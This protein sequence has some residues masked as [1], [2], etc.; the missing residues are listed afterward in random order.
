MNKYIVALV[1]LIAASNMNAN[2]QLVLGDTYNTGFN[3]AVALA[4][5]ATDPNFTI[6]SAPVGQSTGINPV[7]PTST[8][9]AWFTSATAQYISPSVD[10]HYPPNQTNGGDLPGDYDYQAILNTSFL[11]PT[12]VDFTGSYAADNTASVTIGGINVTT[13]LAPPNS[14]FGGPLV[15]FTFSLLVGAGSQ[16]THI[17]FIVTNYNSDNSSPVNSDGLNNPIGLLVSNFRATATPEPSTYAMLFA[18]LGSLLLVRR[19]RRTAAL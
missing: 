15:P 8:P 13:A 9:S 4:P 3:G 1:S 5:G 12:E 16:N 6:V 19:M 2:A 11:V 18:G 10:Q 7:V 17:D 14:Q